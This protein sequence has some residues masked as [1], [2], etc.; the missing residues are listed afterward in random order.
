MEIKQELPQ[1]NLALVTITQT[2]LSDDSVEGYRYLLEFVPYG[3]EQEQKWQ[4]VWAG[5]Q[6][7]CWQGRGQQNWGTDLCH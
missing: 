7:R 6:W 3:E 4:L 2:K 1:E 5:E